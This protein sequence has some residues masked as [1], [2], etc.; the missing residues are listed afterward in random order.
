MPDAGPTTPE[1][2]E[3]IQ[4]PPAGSSAVKGDGHRPASEVGED[5]PTAGAG[6]SS[7]LSRQDS[8]TIDHILHTGGIG[9]LDQLPDGVALLNHE[10]RILW[11][12]RLLYEFTLRNDSAASAAARACEPAQPETAATET[13]RPSEALIGKTFYEAFGTPEI[14]GPDFCPLHTALGS[15][16][17]AKSSL[18]VG[19]KTYF[20][21]QAR[22]VSTDGVESPNLLV[23][24]VRDIS[25]EVLQRQK[26]NA[27]YQA[28]LELGD[29]SLDDILQ[30]SVDE[31][32][33]LLKS[34]ILH[35]TQ[36]LLRFET[37]E[38]RLLD[39][40]TRH[41]EPLLAVG[42]EPGAATRP[43]EIGRASCRER[44]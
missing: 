17:L 16:E 15:G 4:G 12:N 24:T 5:L 28:G 18:R 38:I 31:R 35:Y 30:M 34:K 23:V 36:D 8:A 32:I 26:L 33:D 44:V 13:K 42:M 11:C 20:E 19:E 6:S 29:L 39:K 7:F 27:I 14:I 1:A 9:I 25:A 37:V 10:L 3:R 40:S 21:V 2:G 43:R 41:L 22:P